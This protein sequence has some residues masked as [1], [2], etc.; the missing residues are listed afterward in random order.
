MYMINIISVSKCTA[1][2]FNRR[3]MAPVII[4]KLGVHTY[5]VYTVPFK[6]PSL[7]IIYDQL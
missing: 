2:S 3:P 7:V 5:T 1:Y 4:F 6:S